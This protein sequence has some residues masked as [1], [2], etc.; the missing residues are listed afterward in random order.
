MLRLGRNVNY[1]DR[2]ISKGLSRSA[3]EISKPSGLICFFVKV[4]F[5]DGVYDSRL[6]ILA[7]TSKIGTLT[8]LDD[9]LV[10]VADLAKIENVI[11]GSDD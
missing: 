10:N 2:R 3:N 7:I 11:A 9:E 6:T 4:E 1:T 8:T 5:S